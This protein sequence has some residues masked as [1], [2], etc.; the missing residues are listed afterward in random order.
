MNTG[1]V[2]ANM[3]TSGMTKITLLNPDDGF[4]YLPF[5]GMDFCF[6]GNNYGNS[7]GITTGSIYMNI[8]NAF[9]F[10]KGSVNWQTWNVTSPAILFDF[11]DLY[12]LDLYVSPIQ[13]GPVL[14]VKYLR[15]VKTG[16]DRDSYLAGSRTVK[17]AYEI[18]YVR[19]S[20]YQY[21]QFN[22]SVRDTFTGVFNITDGSSFKNTFGTFNTPVAGCS[23]V[24]RS[25]LNGYDWTF[26]PNT[27]L[28]F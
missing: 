2:I 21:M 20:R 3:N 28:N 24:L 17:N 27:H 5:T 26:F 18:Y 16:I 19:D 23:Y 8:N 25:D 10:G 14:G 9:G 12:N 7:T 4:L 22:C 11:F 1:D 6:Y 13:S 15:I